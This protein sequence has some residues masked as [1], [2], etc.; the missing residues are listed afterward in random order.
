VVR[1]AVR[2]VTGLRI[3]R[4][5]NQW[6]ARSVTEE[7]ERLNVTRIVVAA[8]LV[9][10]DKDRRGLP[11]FRIAPHL[12]N[13][14]F[15]ISFEQED[16]EA[17]TSGPGSRALRRLPDARRQPFFPFGTNY[18]STESN[19]WDFSGPRNAA[20]WEQ[21]FAEMQTHGVSFVRTGIWND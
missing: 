4:N 17:L 18:F 15:D 9:H 13:D 19:G 21:D 5:H 1:I 16:P 11:N 12:I 7:I 10:R 20:V 14:L 2:D 6:N 3:R 8:A